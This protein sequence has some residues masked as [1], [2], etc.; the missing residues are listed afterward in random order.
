MASEGPKG[1]A[2]DPPVGASL[3]SN[4]LPQD[5]LIPHVGSCATLPPAPNI[6]VEPH[7]I[8]TLRREEE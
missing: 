6:K 7:M 3:D 1:C 4:I 5:R 8:F 2:K